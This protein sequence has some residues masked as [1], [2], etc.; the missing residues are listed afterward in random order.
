MKLVLML[1]LLLSTP[2][3]SK[4]SQEYLNKAF[5][6][7]AKATGVDEELIRAVCWVESNHRPYAYRHSDSSLGHSFGICQVLAERGTDQL[8]RCLV[9]L[10][11]E[12]LDLS[13]ERRWKR[14]GNWFSIG[15]EHTSCNN[16]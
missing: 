1:G 14:N 12:P 15:H 11:S 3:Y 6:K 8:G 16:L 5:A 4:I 7:A 10:L 9:L 2:A 13:E